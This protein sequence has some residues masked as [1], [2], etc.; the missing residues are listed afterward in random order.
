VEILTGYD[1]VYEPIAFTFFTIQSNHRPSIKRSAAVP[2]LSFTI[3]KPRPAP[4]PQFHASP[5]QLVDLACA[6]EWTE[7]CLHCYIVR[8]VIM[9][10]CYHIYVVVS[11][12]VH[13][14]Q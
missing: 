3:T 13:A 8:F 14:K 6:A 2:G 12:C 4:G 5:D 1:T 10:V 11:H 7:G 9:E